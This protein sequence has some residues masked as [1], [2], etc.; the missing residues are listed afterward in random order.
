M[1]NSGGRTVIRI[2]AVAAL[3]AGLMAGSAEAAT[4][5]VTGN[6]VE[7]S[8]APTST[9]LNQLESGNSAFAFDEQ[10]GFEL[11]SPLV[12]N[13]IV[14]GPES[15][16]FVNR[17]LPVGTVVASHLVHS[18]P[19]KDTG[20]TRRIGAVTYDSDIIAIITTTALL[21]RSDFL[22]APGTTYGGTRA[23]RGFEARVPPAS[24][25][26]NPV[27]DRFTISPDRRT[28][29]LDF[30][31]YLVDE[32]RVITKSVT[33]LET[34]I[35]DSPDP[36]TLHNDVQYTV[37][38]KNVTAAP[39]N[40]DAVLTVPTGATV[41][42][43]PGCSIT[44]VVTCPLGSLAAGA[45]ASVNIIVT[46]PPSGTS[47]TAT[48]TAT[49]GANPIASETTTIENVTTDDTKGWVMPGQSL[50]TPADDPAT[51]ELPN[52]GSG[53]PV[54]IKQN[55]TPASFCGGPCAGPTTS[56]EPIP[57]YTNPAEPLRLTVAWN[58]T[59]GDP[60]SV[61]DALSA[62]AIAFTKSMYV[63]DPGNP[64]VGTLLA[65]CTTPGVAIPDPCYNVN[66]IQEPA[67]GNF[68]VFTVVLYGGQAIT[69]GRAA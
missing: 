33:T 60:Q 36:V 64:S 48:A 35:V 38:V 11:T 69:V 27:A 55:M 25:S 20:Q 26:S 56:V 23:A 67:F 9:T 3:V 21:S 58:F 29:N 63:Q 30:K 49:P 10:Q 42:S 59:P 22:G 24:P 54:L 19:I 50:A 43:A 6:I 15:T 1:R 41:V 52:N 5:G 17:R 8:S 34:T 53:A 46:T 61:P 44:T 47:M 12:V 40:A 57:G 51:V 16:G 65:K 37:T 66:L 68:V 14:P 45:D 62:A 28:I 2:L 7:L 13:Y 18:D 32:I 31:T 39:M 4:I